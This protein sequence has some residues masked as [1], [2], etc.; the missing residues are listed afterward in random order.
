[1][2][3]AHEEDDVPQRP[4]KQPRH[5]N[6]PAVVMA[7]HG[8]V[9]SVDFHEDEPPQLCNFTRDDE[10]R[11]VRD[12]LSGVLEEL[13]AGIL[14][15]VNLG[16]SSR[17]SMPV[18]EADPCSSLSVFMQPS[19]AIRLKVRAPPGC[20]ALKF[21][22]T[23]FQ[24]LRKAVLE[25]IGGDAC[26]NQVS[27]NRLLNDALVA[28]PGDLAKQQERFWACAN[29]PSQY[30]VR[31][32]NTDGNSSP[33]EPIFIGE[34]LKVNIQ[35]CNRLALPVSNVHDVRVNVDV[36]ATSKLRGQESTL[37]LGTRCLEVTR[38][39]ANG[40]WDLRVLFLP[41][42]QPSTSHPMSYALRVT[43]S[44]G[45]RG[46]SA[47]WTFRE[48][49]EV[50]GEPEIDVRDVHAW[51]KDSQYGR[52]PDRHQMLKKGGEAEI[53]SISS[54]ADVV[55]HLKDEW[56]RPPDATRP[57][58]WTPALQRREFL[59]DVCM[60]KR[61][62]T[63]C[64]RYVAEF[65]GWY[66]AESGD[67]GAD[68]GGFCLAKYEGTVDEVLHKKPSLSERFALAL[69]AAHTMQRL[70]Q[71]FPRLV[72]PDVKPNNFLLNQPASGG[73]AAPKEV[74]LTD[75][76]GVREQGRHAHKGSRSRTTAFSMLS[77]ASPQ[78]PFAQISF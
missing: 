24:Q 69:G 52:T 5:G 11:T 12:W 2:A 47:R 10:L 26:P 57:I 18:N 13:P 22:L 23:P 46:V 28:N 33:T 14:Q 3:D 67:D 78:S 4:S 9:V 48:E 8:S 76:G 40:G 68:E 25:T 70:H 30:K 16:S 34:A 27:L 51:H 31:V 21:G 58:G 15:I 65:K 37:E 39:N 29:V 17:G 71:T 74:V 72:F 60:W 62:S 55:R 66:L 77:R 73:P 38:R 7:T 56:W 42:E 63:K 53:W 32:L 6:P 59:K 36:I 19:G 50:E 43:D 44:N 41:K 45:I 20:D 35:L 49:V 75:L 54:S 64:P 1:M 61:L